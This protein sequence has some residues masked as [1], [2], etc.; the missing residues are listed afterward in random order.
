MK[1]LKETTDSGVLSHTELEETFEFD[2]IDN[3]IEIIKNIDL[4]EQSGD[5][6]FNNDSSYL[7]FNSTDKQ[8]LIKIL[9]HIDRSGASI[10]KD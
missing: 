6:T 4:E 10:D 9:K 5:I 8:E 1:D 3:L 2:S 7:C